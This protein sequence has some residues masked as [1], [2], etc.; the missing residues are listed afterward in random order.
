M[1]KMFKVSKRMICVMNILELLLIN[2]VR[3]PEKQV[4]AINI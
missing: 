2:N 3:I 4:G 1:Q